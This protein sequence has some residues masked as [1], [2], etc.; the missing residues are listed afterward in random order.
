MKVEKFVL[1]IIMLALMLC[2]S[3]ISATDIIARL[4]SPT[5]EVVEEVALSGADARIPETWRGHGGEVRFYAADGATLLS[6]LD[7]TLLDRA[8]YAD[9]AGWAHIAATALRTLGTARADSA[10]LALVANYAYN[11]RY[12][13]TAGVALYSLNSS[14]SDTALFA[15][16]AGNAANALF[17]DSARISAFSDS[18]RISFRSIFSDTSNVARR[19]DSANVAA[20][21]HNA[22]FADSTRISAYA[23]S[24]RIA[25]RS[26]YADTAAIA[27]YADSASVADSTRISAFA[28][29]ARISFHSIFAD[30]ADFARN[31]ARNFW[32][33]LTVTPDIPGFD[34][35]G[36]FHTIADALDSV[37]TSGETGWLI[38]VMPGSYV[39]PRDA[40]VP[41]HTVVR[42][43][44]A[45]NVEVDLRS[46]TL[47]LENG[48]S[49]EG[50]HFQ[51]GEVDLLGFDYIFDCIFN[52]TPVI[53]SGSLN[54]IDRTIFT[55]SRTT[56]TA[57]TIDAANVGLQLNNT[58]FDN[59]RYGIVANGANAMIRSAAAVFND[60]REGIY[61]TGNLATCLLYDNVF[62]ATTT[63]INAWSRAVVVLDAATN[64]TASISGA[65]V[66][67]IDSAAYVGYL[68]IPASWSWA[69]STPLQVQNA[70]DLLAAQF[71]TV[72]THTHTAN[73]AATSDVSAS[74]AFT[75]TGTWDLQIEA[76]AVTNDEIDN[77]DTY[78]MAGLN[79]NGN[80][81]ITGD[82][83]V[84]GNAQVS[85]K[86]TVI[87]GIDPS[88]LQLTS[89]TTD[90]DIAMR[91]KLW[92]NASHD[93]M[94]STDAG[95]NERILHEGSIAII[96]APMLSDMGASA[97]DV[98]K[99]DGTNWAP[100]P[101]EIAD[102]DT[103]MSN[104]CN[105][106]ITWDNATLELSITDA[107]GTNSATLTGL[108]T[109]GG[110]LSEGAGIANFSYDATANAQVAIDHTWFSGD[111][112]VSS[113]GVVTVAN[114]SINAGDLDTLG[115]YI[116][117]SLRVRNTLD[118][119]GTTT[120]GD[121]QVNGSANF[122]GN[123]AVTGNVLANGT[124]SSTER[125]SAFGG[126]AFRLP[127]HSGANATP[128]ALSFVPLVGDMILWDDTSS[129]H[130]FKVCV[131][132]S[133][134]TWEC[135][136]LN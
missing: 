74:S 54:G 9:Q 52:N 14:Y 8:V 57:I 2:G 87:G 66:I 68:P 113:G 110:T 124:V 58:L 92:V 21:A 23:D 32:H 126:A 101:D 18:A 78:T 88:Y 133:S 45:E 94:F 6:T 104:E 108:L 98:L 82:A 75:V 31:S 121:V 40:S 131:Y 93:L 132:V 27:L 65:N 36:D 17:A 15:F 128:T 106:A 80:A 19:A 41:Y 86:L 11:A 117:N 105:T 63:P 29:S 116:L 77:T 1:R 60:C 130:D 46:T 120:T 70:L 118:I 102:G 125:I 95:T 44:A 129:G 28:D 111:A 20:F 13:D 10:T 115:N 43:E 109:S 42:G 48:A 123:V 37:A 49:L 35:D 84:S 134:S 33:V 122:A 38:R 59:C 51:N 69:L 22:D 91:D 5:G 96:D 7:V 26:I 61:L 64:F 135:M 136:D 97:G 127:L 76:D 112:T 55:G 107:C 85:G 50:I 119:T 71:N 16:E 4:V 81:T 30:T 47:T 99:F 56:Y 103:S 72:A 25:F 83:L 100:A 39:E 12:A 67:P 90:P 79:V 73:I 89:Q 62:V 3:L 53:A 114:G 24:T 34:D